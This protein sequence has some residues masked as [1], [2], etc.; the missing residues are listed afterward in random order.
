MLR[1]SLTLALVLAAMAN[2]A[3]LS[4]YNDDQLDARQ[5]AGVTERSLS[6]ALSEAHTI[7]RRTPVDTMTLVNRGDVDEDRQFSEDKSEEDEE[8]ESDERQ[9]TSHKAEPLSIP[10]SSI[11]V[12]HLEQS[13]RPLLI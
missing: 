13:H 7:S 12:S 9:L 2:A 10:E 8:E 4:L 5:A 6:P 3:P 11:D 1:R